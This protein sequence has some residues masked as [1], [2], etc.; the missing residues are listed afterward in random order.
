MLLDITVIS[1]SSFIV[2]AALDDYEMRY[3]HRHPVAFI[4]LK[5]VKNLL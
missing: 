5:A 1:L 4:S 3:L 2:A